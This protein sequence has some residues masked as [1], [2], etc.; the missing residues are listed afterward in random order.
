MTLCRRVWPLLVQMLQHHSEAI[1]RKG[2]ASIIDVT[3]T[4]SSEFTALLLSEKADMLGLLLKLL[5]STDSVE[6]RSYYA[7]LL[8]IISS[9]SDQ[10]SIKRIQ[11]AGAV[12]CVLKLLNQVKTDRVKTSCVQCLM[13]YHLSIITSTC[14]LQR[15]LFS[16]LYMGPFLEFSP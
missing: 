7:N 16:A 3:H 8:G 2:A 4:A 6:S 13:V 11:D 1:R 10:A 9:H 12:P 15:L 14:V 5:A